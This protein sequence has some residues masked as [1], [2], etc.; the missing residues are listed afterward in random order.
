MPREQTKAFKRNQEAARKKQLKQQALKQRRSLVNRVKKQAVE[1]LAEEVFG[2]GGLTPARQEA[3]AAVVVGP[4][5]GAIT[6]SSPNH[7]RHL[8]RKAREKFTEKAESYMDEHLASVKGAREAGQFD[9]AA[10]HAEWA[11]DAFGDQEE[12]LIER[13]A[14]TAAPTGGSS[15]MVGVNLGGMPKGK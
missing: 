15:V 2:E 12:R 10:R 5:A 1:R 8:V 13:V 3:L 4:D 14:P 6:V 7:L 11:L 9:V